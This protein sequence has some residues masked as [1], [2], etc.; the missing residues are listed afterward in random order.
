MDAPEEF[1]A[2]AAEYQLGETV[3]A[4]V[5]A[6]FAVLCSMHQPSPRKFLLHQKEDVLRDDCLMVSFHVVLRNGAVVFDPLL[7]Q[8][9]CCEGLLKLGITEEETDHD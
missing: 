4:R 9:V 1:T 8:E 7:C 3:V 5:A 6:P 2:V